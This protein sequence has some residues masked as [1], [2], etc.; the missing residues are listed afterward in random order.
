M[1]LLRVL[2][3]LGLF[4]CL[5]ALLCSCVSVSYQGD[6][7]PS[8]PTKVIQVF[9]SV[10][11]LDATKRPYDLIGYLSAEGRHFASRSSMKNRLIEEAAKHGGDGIVFVDVTDLEQGYPITDRGP[12]S[13]GPPNYSGEQSAKRVAAYIVIF[14]PLKTAAPPGSGR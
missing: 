2:G 5:A 13:V 10:G 7:R 8:V 14:L 12:I 11:A 4:G 3:K 6:E 9:E 1:F